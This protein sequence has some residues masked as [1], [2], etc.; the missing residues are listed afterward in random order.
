MTAIYVRKYQR[1]QC[2]E[3]LVLLSEAKPYKCLLHRRLH[4]QDGGAIRAHAPAP[5]LSVSATEPSN[6]AQI[7]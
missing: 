4:R 6:A 2:A 3:C 7:R 1:W 5:A